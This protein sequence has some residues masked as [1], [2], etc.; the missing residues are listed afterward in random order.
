MTH[1]FLWEIDTVMSDPL[2]KIRGNEVHFHNGAIARLPHPVGVV[3]PFG[4]ILVLLV[5]P[6]R[7][8]VYNENVFGVDVSGDILWQIDP[9]Y[10]STEK[11]GTFCALERIGAH[12][13]VSNIKNLAVY[14]DPATGKVVKRKQQTTPW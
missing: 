11:N 14:L 9:Q 13:V 12:A 4:D 7:E 10:P 3:E 5:W 1:R 8:I 2:Y 6:P